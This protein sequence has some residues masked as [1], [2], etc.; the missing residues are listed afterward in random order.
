MLYIAYKA[1]LN[2]LSWKLNRKLLEE[3]L[4]IDLM[5]FTDKHSKINIYRTKGKLTS[6][7]DISDRYTILNLK[8]DLIDSIYTSI[9]TE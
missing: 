3:W 9:Y 7:L 5:N 4:L 8:I 6:V 1:A 2:T